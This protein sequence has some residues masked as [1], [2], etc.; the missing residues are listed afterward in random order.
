MTQF[1]DIIKLLDETSCSQKHLTKHDDNYLPIYSVQA[2]EEA[3]KKL[4]LGVIYNQQHLLLTIIV[5]GDPRLFVSPTLPRRSFLWCRPRCGR[6][7]WGSRVGWTQCGPTSGAGR[8][9]NCKKDIS[10]VRKK[11]FSCSSETSSRRRTLT[12]SICTAWLIS[13]TQQTIW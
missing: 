9:F 6:T 12:I 13:S 10:S 7:L 1:T 4:H 11:Y 2:F 3:N 5:I 8:S